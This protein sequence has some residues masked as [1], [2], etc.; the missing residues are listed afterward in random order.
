VTDTERAD[1]LLE[2][3]KEWW[4]PPDELIATLP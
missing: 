2:L 4:N 1:A 3:L